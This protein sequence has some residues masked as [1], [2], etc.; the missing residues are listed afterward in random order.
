MDLKIIKIRLI[1]VEPIIF[2]AETQRSIR[3][4]HKRTDI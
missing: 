1:G 4:S 3:L 2:G